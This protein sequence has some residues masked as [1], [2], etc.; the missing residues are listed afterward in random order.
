MR[1]LGKT[2]CVKNP[3]V[4]P[5]LH[6][7][8][9]YN[10]SYRQI[11]KLFKKSNTDISLS[12]RMNVQDVST[13]ATLSKWGPRSFDYWMRCLKYMKKNR[14]YDD[15]GA[16]TVTLRNRTGY[17]FK[18]LSSNWF[19]ASHGISRN[20]IFR[21]DEKCYRS[22]I[23]VTGPVQWIHVG[24][25]NK[26]IDGVIDQC[27][28][29]NG[30]NDEYINQPRV[31]FLCGKCNCTE[32]GPKV[33]TSKEQLQYSVGNI[34]IPKLEWEVDNVRRNSNSLYWKT[35]YLYMKIQVYF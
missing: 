19:F 6:V 14:Y 21:G 4:T 2:G 3:R 8:P 31:F 32:R 12:N 28:I 5:S 18:Q 1:I 33:I 26:F 27:K 11:F 16:A 23:V 15:Q 22:S 20:G 9:C 25:P 34:T 13:A 17:T 10:T 24:I 30:N 35:Y 29:M 7:F